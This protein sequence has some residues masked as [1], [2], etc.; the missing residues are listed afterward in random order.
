MGQ[1]VRKKKREAVKA[2]LRLKAKKQACTACN[3][4]FWED[5]LLYGPNPFQEE[6]NGD[7]TNVWL[8]ADCHHEA[9]MDI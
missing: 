4:V 3:A 8:C 6:I 2:K 9:L 5:E 7:S 1:T